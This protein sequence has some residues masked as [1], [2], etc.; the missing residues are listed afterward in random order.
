M[1]CNL[2][3]P[4]IGEDSRRLR[5]PKLAPGIDNTYFLERIFLKI[6]RITNFRPLKKLNSDLYKLYIPRKDIYHLK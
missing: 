1:H 4:T 3:G 5:G 2:A 6:R